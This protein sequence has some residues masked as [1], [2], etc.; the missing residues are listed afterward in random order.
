MIENPLGM[1]DIAHHQE[2]CPEL[3]KLQSFNPA[4]Y[5]TKEINSHNLVVYQEKN[6]DRLRIC[7][8]SSIVNQVV[9]WYHF[10]LGHCG[11]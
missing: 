10:A 11:T 5:P 9:K 1:N 6:E 3:R 7:L 2:R 8:L 4:K